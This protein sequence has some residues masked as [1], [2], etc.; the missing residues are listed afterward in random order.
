MHLRILHNAN[1]KCVVD[2]NPKPVVE[3]LHNGKRLRGDDYVK[4]IND[5]LVYEQ[6]WPPDDLGYYQCIAL[7]KLGSIQASAKLFIYRQGKN[8]K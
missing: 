6:V 5:S 3:W 7:N 8:L 4:I 2:G 1:F